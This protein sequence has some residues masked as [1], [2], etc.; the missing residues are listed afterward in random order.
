MFSM[1]KSCGK[2][3][4]HIVKIFYL[5]NANSAQT[6]FYFFLLMLYKTSTCK[7]FWLCAVVFLHNFYSLK[8]IF[9][10]LFFLFIN[11]QIE[12]TLKTQCLFTNIRSGSVNHYFPVGSQ[13]LFF[14]RTGF[15]YVKNWKNSENRSITTILSK[16]TWRMPIL[17]KPC[18]TSFF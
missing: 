6:V 9:C 16:V 11:L 4:Q 10:F 3:Q 18:C 5:A 12:H 13:K 7:I 2:K 17:H 15:V 1:N 8:A 14:S